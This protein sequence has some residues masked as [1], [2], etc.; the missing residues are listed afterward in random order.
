MFQKLGY[1]PYVIQS[2][3]LPS[4]PIPCMYN[5]NKNSWLANRNVPV[6]QHIIFLMPGH[7]PILQPTFFEHNK[8]T[9]EFPVTWPAHVWNL[10]VP[11]YICFIILVFSPT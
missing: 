6:E 3:E 4:D 11:K 7:F 1:K 5:D 8:A 2:N 10:H 9:I